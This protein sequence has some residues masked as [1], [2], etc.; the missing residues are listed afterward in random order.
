MGSSGLVAHG[1]VDASKGTP[2]KEH[3]V[4]GASKAP[5]GGWPLSQV[6]SQGRA[7]VFELGHVK[8]P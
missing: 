8:L 6:F 2:T 1:R 5:P 3:R 4:G 7:V